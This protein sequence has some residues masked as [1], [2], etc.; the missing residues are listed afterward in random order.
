MKDAR[1]EE[2]PLSSE[3]MRGDV[4]DDG[5]RTPGALLDFT[6]SA[7]HASALGLISGTVRATQSANAVKRGDG[8]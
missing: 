3:Q 6:L 7:L 2:D 4:S 5:R 1:I 8:R